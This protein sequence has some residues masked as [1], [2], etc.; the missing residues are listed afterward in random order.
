MNRALPASAWSL[1]LLMLS[2]PLLLPFSRSAELPLLVGA[3]VGVVALARRRAQ[4]LHAAAARALLLVLGAYCV[5]ALISAI[6]AVAPA[7]SWSTALASLRLLAFAVGML[8]LVEVALARGVE[9]RRLST[10]LAWVGALPLALWSADALLQ[11]ATGYSL[12]GPLQ[13]DRLSGIFGADD[14]KLGPLLPALAPL[15]LW[16]L[17]QG[18]RAAL[19]LAW[20]ALLL[21]VL[22]AGSRAGWISYALVSG[23]LAWRL[24][25]GSWRALG[26]WVVAATLIALTIA[27]LAYQAS[28]SFRARVDRTLAAGSG[29][30]DVA[31]AGRVPIFGTAIRM[32]LAHPVNGVGVRGFRNAYPTFAEPGDPWVDPVQQTGAAHAHQILLELLT[33]VGLIGLALWLGAAWVLWRCARQSS[34]ALAQAPWVALAVL[35]FPLNTHLA[36]YSSFIGIV[37]TWLLVLACL[38]GRLQ[39]GAPMQGRKP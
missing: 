17:L 34:G 18:P 15:L 11:A 5:A 2:I 1:L 24:A 23:L 4:L 38:Q 12:G 32:A 30:V 33:E 13:A 29:Q 20:L 35:V 36:F 25:R 3:M 8:A 16:P 14:L 37:L 22:L 10:G 39:A 9:S 6:D 19:A 21:V 27:A 28:D 26:G 7:K 31:L